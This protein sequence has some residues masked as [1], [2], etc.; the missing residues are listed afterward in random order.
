[1]PDLVGGDRMIVLRIKAPA[2]VQGKT[3]VD[4]IEGTS[5]ACHAVLQHF[6]GGGVGSISERWMHR[7]LQYTCS[8]VN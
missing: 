7:L 8:L 4:L 2:E 5:L 6:R 3:V 1:M